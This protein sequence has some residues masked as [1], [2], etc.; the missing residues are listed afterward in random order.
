VFA[1][2]GRDLAPRPGEGAVFNQA[3]IELGALVCRA[4]APRCGVCP[5]QREC[6]WDGDPIRTRAPSVRFEDSDRWV[7]G[8][9]VAALAA[10]GELPAVEPE[11]LERALNGLVQDGLIQRDGDAL[12]LG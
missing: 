2:L 1:R 11:R 8:R 6:R 7:R 5:L 10:G 12:R 3:A 9:V 4:R